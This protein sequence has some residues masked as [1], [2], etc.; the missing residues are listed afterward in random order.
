MQ[1]PTRPVAV[2]KDL[3]AG[4]DPLMVSRAE[5]PNAGQIVFFVTHCATS[6]CVDAHSY[7]RRS[8]GMRKRLAMLAY[9]LDLL[10]TLLQDRPEQCSC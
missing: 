5:H 9:K 3:L 7:S 8:Q 1:N 10:S 6:L 2:C 4:I